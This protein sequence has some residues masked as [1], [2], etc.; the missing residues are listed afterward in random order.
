M[1]Y[2]ILALDMDGT[3]LNSKR[4][5]SEK[6]L[7]AIR[8]AT[9]LGVIVTIATGRTWTGFRQYAEVLEPQHPII[10]CNGGK[11]VS[12]DGREIYFEQNLEPEAALEIMHHGQAY[13]ATQ[14]IWTDER[15]YSFAETERLRRYAAVAGCDFTILTDEGEAL[16]QQ[17]ITKILWTADAEQIV[18]Y[19]EALPKILKADV[20][21]S[22]SSPNFLEFVDSQVSKGAALSKFAAHFEMDPAEIIAV[23]DAMNDLTML[24]YAGLGVAMENAPDELKEHADFITLTND[25]DG[26]THVIERFIVSGE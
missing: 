2:K 24:Q 20:N 13:G 3:V 22:T 15:L 14:I 11:I 17:G 8:Q 19:Q 5:I 4:Q 26:V 6:T 12:P 10:L 25:A 9:E 16:A 1:N 18:Q 7:A 23:G 21:D